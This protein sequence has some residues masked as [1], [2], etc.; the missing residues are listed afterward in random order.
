M[1]VNLR[2]EN[3]QQSPF[4][5]ENKVLLLSVEHLSS[6]GLFTVTTNKKENQSSKGEK[7]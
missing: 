6:Y 1:R 7:E 4:P 2:G 3:V 5:G